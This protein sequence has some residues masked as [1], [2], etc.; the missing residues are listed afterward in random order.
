MGEKRKRST[1]VQVRNHTPKR[2]SPTPHPQHEKNLEPEIPT[3][4]TRDGPLPVT[5]NPQPEDLPLRDFKS[6]A[7]RYASTFTIL[8]AECA[9]RDLCDGSKMLA[10]SLARSQRKWVDGDIFEK[11][12]IKPLKSRKLDPAVLEKNPGKECMVKLGN[13]QLHIVPH[14]FDIRLFQV[15]RPIQEPPSHPPPSP[16][17][18]PPQSQQHCF[19]PTVSQQG[20]HLSHF[21]ASAPTPQGL[22]PSL[23]QNSQSQPQTSPTAPI[24]H[25]YHSTSPP[26]TQTQNAIRQPILQQQ[27]QQQSLPALYPVAQVYPHSVQAQ[28]LAPQHSRVPAEG[29]SDSTTRPRPSQTETSTTRQ[30]PHPQAAI[31]PQGPSGLVQGGPEAATL[32]ISPQPMHQQTSQQAP[33]SIQQRPFVQQSQSFG[34]VGPPSQPDPPRPDPVIQML[35]M[36]AATDVKLK[37]LMRIV[38]SGKA[39]REQLQ[40]FQGYIDTLTAA[41]NNPPIGPPGSQSRPGGPPPLVQQSQPQRQQIHPQP[42]PQQ[43][44]HHQTHPMHQNQHTNPQYP[45]HTQQHQMYQ[46]P[47]NQHLQQNYRQNPQPLPVQQRTQPQPKVR[48]IPQPPKHET[49]GIVFEFLDS[50]SQGD[51]FLFPKFAILEYLNRGTTVKASFIVTRKPLGLIDEHYQPITIALQCHYPRVLEHLKMIVA[52][53]DATRNHIKQI[54]ENTKRVDN[55]FLVYRLRRESGEVVPDK[56]IV[57]ARMDPPPRFKNRREPVTPMQDVKGCG[58]STTQPRSTGPKVKHVKKVRTSLASKEKK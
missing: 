28:P 53:P 4:F 57:E 15:L 13:A 26:S 11:F 8:S 10:E 58:S 21:Q 27:E 44:M 56:A 52:D 20:G 17:L 14:K 37:E 30:L 16:H 47:H 24:Q 54:M 22:G 23:I 45:T 9:D 32:L 51:R 42:Q 36:K 35:A 18:P 55:S 46:H 25:P 50:Y 40:E 7:E 5:S 6:V 43:Q 34:N 3:F 41:S 1:T 19:S 2:Q 48:T 39:T 12:W 33:Q 29:A 31:R 38:A 49:V